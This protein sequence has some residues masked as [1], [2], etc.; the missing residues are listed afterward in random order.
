M[1]SKRE[2]FQP[3]QTQKKRKEPT[4]RRGNYISVNGP[5]NDLQRESVR[6]SGTDVRLCGGE[7]SRVKDFQMFTCDKVNRRGGAKKKQVSHQAFKKKD[8]KAGSPEWNPTKP[9]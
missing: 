5:S 2:C 9:E 1:G 4:A 3:F 6:G 8:M 7:K